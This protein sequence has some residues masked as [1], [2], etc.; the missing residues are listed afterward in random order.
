MRLSV[1]V[2]LV[3]AVLSPLC[4]CAVYVLQGRPSALCL[5]WRRGL[6]WQANHDQLGS[7][8]HKELRS[9]RL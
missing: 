9:R 5:V 4:L 2:G 6:L 8:A 7:P 1:V 3:C